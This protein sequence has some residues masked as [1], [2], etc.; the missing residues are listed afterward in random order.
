MNLTPQDNEMFEALHQSPVGKR[1]VL[2]LSRL[3]DEIC[4]VRTWN[5]SDSK[6]SVQRASSYIQKYLVDKINLRNDKKDS[7]PEEYV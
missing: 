4:N 7:I 3:Q 6:E 5:D 1:L 2:Y